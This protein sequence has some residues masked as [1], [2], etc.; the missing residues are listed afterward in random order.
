MHT[1]S[2]IDTTAAWKKL[3]FIL[4]VRSEDCR[5]ATWISWVACR[6]E[7]W[8]RGTWVS[9]KLYDDWRFSTLGERK[10]AG[11]R[12][13]WCHA[14][15]D[16]GLVP[17]DPEMKGRKRSVPVWSLQNRKQVWSQKKEKGPVVKKHTEAEMIRCF[18]LTYG[19]LVKAKRSR[20]VHWRMC[21]PLC[22]Y[23]LAVPG[24]LLITQL[25]R[26]K[27]KQEK[28]QIIYTYIYI[29]IY[30]SVVVS[31]L[32]PVYN[33]SRRTVVVLFNS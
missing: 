11:R 22:E 14:A 33:S 9:G 32:L 6:E 31:L 1:Y 2:S 13:S 19:S 25:F 20:R 30:I 7:E 15:Q 4:S 5:N 26:N 18:E 24:S 23:I 3:R 10:R 16:A 8:L 27:E 12:I 28:K 29:Y 17:D 21:I